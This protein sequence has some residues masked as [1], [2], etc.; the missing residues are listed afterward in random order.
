MLPADPKL[1]GWD[2]CAGWRR[3]MAAMLIM[4]APLALERDPGPGARLAVQLP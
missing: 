4:R 3:G 1:G 2:G